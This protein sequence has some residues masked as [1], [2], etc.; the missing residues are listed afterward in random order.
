MKAASP[1]PTRPSSSRTTGTSCVAS[2]G[3]TSVSCAPTSVWNAPSTASG[4][5]RRKSTSTTPTSASPTT[6]IELRNLVSDSPPDHTQRAASPRE[7]RPALQPRLSGHAATRD[8]D[9]HSAAPELTH[10]RD[11][12][13]SATR[14]ASVGDRIIACQSVGKQ[15]QRATSARLGTQMQTQ[16]ARARPPYR[17]PTS[18]TTGSPSAAI[19]SSWLS[20]RSKQGRQVSRTRHAIGA[21]KAAQQ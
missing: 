17:R 7:P 2:C 15:D 14:G 9:G 4:S 16:P 10:T 18:T 13:A 19:N 11:R 5:W 1:M 20:R 8:G 12:C 6:L 3:T 21:E